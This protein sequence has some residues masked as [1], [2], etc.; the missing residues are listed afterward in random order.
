M[1]A[2]QINPSGK[3]RFQDTPG[4]IE[5]H[6]SLLARPEYQ[7]AEDFALMHYMRVLTHETSTSQNPQVTATING[8]KATGVHEFL[9]E[10]RNLAEKAV[11]PEPP[12]RNRVLNHGAQ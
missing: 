1:T 8:W 3:T 2:A 10:F 12:G 9:N 6:H 11:V 4:A 7:Q 5:A